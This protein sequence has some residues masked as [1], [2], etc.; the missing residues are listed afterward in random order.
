MTDNEMMT[1]IHILSTMLRRLL[2]PDLGEYQK[3]AEE[4]L[5]R[6]IHTHEFGDVQIYEELETKIPEEGKIAAVK[7][8]GCLMYFADMRTAMDYV[9]RMAEEIEYD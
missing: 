8:A 6:P 7:I 9:Y 4:K 2:Q 3:W 5:G 1:Y